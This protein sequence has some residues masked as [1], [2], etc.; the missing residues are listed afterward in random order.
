MLASRLAKERNVE[1][2]RERQ[3]LR[4]LQSHRDEE[5]NGGFSWLEGIEEMHSA[6]HAA[7]SSISL[8][9]SPF[10]KVA[11]LGVT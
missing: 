6:R 5:E 4:E 10:R 9:G 1:Q 2:E 11:H 7:S 3:S 8:N